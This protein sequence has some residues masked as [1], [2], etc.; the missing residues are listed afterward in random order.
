M[1]VDELLKLSQGLLTPIIGIATT[2]I[3]YQQWKTNQNKLNLDRYEKRLQVYKEVVRYISVAV[4]DASYGNDEL[5]TFRSKVSDA[6]FL[7]GEEVP[8]Y[9]DEL[10]RRT[11]ML[12]QWNNEYRDYSQ[13]QPENYDHQK[14]VDEKNRELMWILEQYEPARNIFKKYLDISK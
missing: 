6:D 7:F 5:M 11:V 8:K 13:P 2:Y 10:H 4:R 3:A 1:S 9:I 14:V 12:A